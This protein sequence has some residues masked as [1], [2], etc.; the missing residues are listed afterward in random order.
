VEHCIPP[1]EAIAKSVNLGK[2]AA[3]RERTARSAF[4]RINIDT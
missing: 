1:R 4:T 3:R 2:S